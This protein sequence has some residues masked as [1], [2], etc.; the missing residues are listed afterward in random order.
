VSNETL[1]LKRLETTG[2][3]SIFGHYSI[4]AMRKPFLPCMLIVLLA[5]VVLPMHGVGPSKTVLVIYSNERSLPANIQADEGLREALGVNT[6][7]DLKYQ[8]E[9]LDYPHYG[10]VTDEAYD[11]LMSGFLREKYA[12]QH[13][14]VIVAGGPQAFRFL[15]HHQDDLFSGIPILGIVTGPSSAVDL[16]ST[17]FLDIPVSV[18]PRP[19]LELAVRLQPKAREIVVITGTSKF[20]LDWEQRIRAAFEG[21]TAH[22]P[23]RYLSGLALDDILREL[24]RLPANTIVYTHGPQQDGSGR[25]YTPRD[26]VHRMAEA[27]SAPVY[28]SYSTMITFGIVG[29]YVFDMG[30]EGRQA[31]QVVKRILAGEKLTQK[32]MPNALP[33]SY[34]V[35]WKQIERWHLPEANL[36][37]GTK[38]VNRVPD[39]WQ[40]YKDYLW[41]IA[42]LFAVEALLILYLLAERRR[43]RIAQEQ[44]AQRLQVEILVAQVSSEFAN[45]QNGQIDSAILR[46]LQSL[47]EFSRSSFVCIGQTQNNEAKLLCTHIWP[48]EA[49]GSR[50]VLS[51]SD[52]PNMVRRLS[53]GETVMF[54]GK[55]EARE[56]EDYESFHKVGIRSLLAVPIQNEHHFL[57]ALSLV[58]VTEASSWRADI[59]PQLNTIADI[60][61]GALARRHTALALRESEVLKGV[62][63]DYMQSNV[64]VV[65]QDGVI[66]EVNQHWLDF[67][68]RNGAPSRLS[69]GTG[70]NYLDV[71]RE[72]IG[73]EEAVEASNGI[74]SVL[75]GLRQTFE[76]EYACNSPSEM[77]WFRMTVI[78]LPG[79]KGGALIIHFNITQQKLADL[80]RERMQEETAQLHRATEMGQLVASLAHELAQPLAA[81]LSNAQAASYLATS[82][83]P[84]LAEIN[85]ALR[86]IIEDDQRARSVLNNVRAL[87]KKHVITP[88]RVD[89][90]LIVEDVTQIVR[91]SAQL[92]GIQIKLS[93]FESPV[94]VQG[95]EVPLQQVLLNLVNNAID[96]MSQVPMERRV[97]TLKTAIQ[98]RTG[99]GLLVVEDQGSG[100]PDELRTKLFQPFFTTKSEGLGMG[101][102]ICQTI[103]QTLGG[104]IRLQDNGD[105]GAT[106]HVLL[107]A[108]V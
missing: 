9:Y 19:T 20:D 83:E 104:S 33:S 22:P 21:W 32:D 61:G 88:H 44:L 12:G 96:A 38:I 18:E 53:H 76:S 51:P 95:D 6:S 100:V 93:L 82:S 25:A 86:D 10:D 107:P 40:K 1:D 31:G 3:I 37:P 75:S 94:F 45:L 36:P 7:L 27:S 77:R 16:T 14:N 89:L 54:P 8:T 46:S 64:V 52:F 56:S 90:N 98:A 62:I 101:L 29:G 81:V 84:D 97:I 72:D 50:P 4:E 57:G 41:G 71:C 80:E 43:R 63:L 106:F 49:D 48:E 85:A 39:P 108:A 103:L 17:R 58:N 91:S 67:A 70:A 68:A 92:R 79:S 42:L 35:D 55:A 47:Q 66:L 13:I 87:L 23:V 60:L 99:S 5:T 26:V 105:T 15:H 30:D 74:R 28:S 69:V 2:V 102:A 11:R 24:S 78:R 59:L 34:V 73:S 65:D